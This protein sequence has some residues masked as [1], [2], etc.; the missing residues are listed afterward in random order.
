MAGTAHSFAAPPNLHD[1]ALWV[2]VFS[3]WS[4]PGWQLWM[5]R[6]FARRSGGRALQVGQ[7]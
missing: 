5:W 4:K 1:P 2:P 3:R 7:I 6:S